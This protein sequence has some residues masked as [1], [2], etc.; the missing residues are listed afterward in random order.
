MRKAVKYSAPPNVRKRQLLRSGKVVQYVF[1]FYLKIR[2]YQYFL[3]QCP[4]FLCSISCFC[5]SISC[6]SRNCSLLI[7]N[8][9]LLSR[10]FSPCIVDDLTLRLAFQQAVEIAFKIAILNNAV[11]FKFCFGV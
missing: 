6:F 4:V 9:R 2:F 7:F 10:L 5:F 8:W 11:F 3:V 1:S